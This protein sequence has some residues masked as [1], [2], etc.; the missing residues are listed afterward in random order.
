MSGS[1]SP[2]T[3]DDQITSIEPHFFFIYTLAAH[4]LQTRLNDTESRQLLLVKNYANSKSC[5]PNYLLQI[6]LNASQGPRSNPEVATF[7]LNTCLSKLLSSPS[8]DYQSV[9]LVLRKLIS[10]GAVHKSDTDDDA[11]FGMYKQAYRIMVGLKAGEYPIEEGKSL[12]MTAW[13]RAALPVQLGQTG[14]AKKWMHMGLELAAKVPGMET[15]KSYMEDFLAGLEKKV[16][17]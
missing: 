4:D 8:P 11:V 2:Q 10:L 7:S 1:T 12:V 15:Y 9:A 13:N 14:E 6:G 17:S 3:D 5:N 16:P